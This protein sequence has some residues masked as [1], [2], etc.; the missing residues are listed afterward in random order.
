[1]TR[2]EGPAPVT[3]ELE[4]AAADRGLGTQR[5]L[6][7]VAGGV[8]VLGIGAG[9]VF[10]LSSKSKHDEAEK[11]CDGPR[12]VDQR[13]VDAGN[14]AYSAGTLSTVCM[15]IGG[16]ALAGGAVLWFTAKR[17][18]QAP[19]TALGVGPGTVTLRGAF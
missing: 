7:L 3:A 19:A 10:G 12:C 11:Y 17:P 2:T 1:L 14:D 15:A 18:E 4:P 8:G 5:V 9:T 16:A 13:G 6:A